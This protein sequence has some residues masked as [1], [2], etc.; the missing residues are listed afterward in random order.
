M[1]GQQERGKDEWSDAAIGHD[2]RWRPRE[3]PDVG[4]S[5]RIRQVARL[6]LP[7][8]RGTC[9]RLGRRMRTGGW[10]VPSGVLTAWRKSTSVAAMPSQRLTRVAALAA[11]S[12]FSAAPAAAITKCKA[13]T[14]DDGTI[15]LSARDIVGTPRWGLRYDA[16]TT[17][18]DDTPSCV[19]GGLARECALAPVGSPERTELPP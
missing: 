11:A 5:V 15:A 3:R 14:L 12:L 9:S 18:L 6:D 16:E 17:P 8:P 7:P 10:R 13:K 4:L 1:R 2:A 19:D